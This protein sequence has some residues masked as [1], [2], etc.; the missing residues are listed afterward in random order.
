MRYK[1]GWFIPQQIM[2]L[3]HLVP[4]VTA[5]DFVGIMSATNACLQDARHPFHL[6]IDNRMI[7]S[8]QVVS[9]GVILQTISQ[10]QQSPL[11]W[12]V[13]V[14]PHHLRDTADNREIQRIG[15]VQLRYVD[16]LAT[17][18]DVLQ[19]E[20]ASINWDIRVTDFFVE[21]IHSGN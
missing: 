2:A 18:F 3:T 15:D 12:V 8:D 11:R 4:E 9:L 19:K 6:I 7:K 1:A 14:L 16:R 17:A 5:D 20:D 13:M 21:D 10:L